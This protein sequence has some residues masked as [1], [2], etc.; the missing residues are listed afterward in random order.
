M[1]TN[2][3]LGRSALLQE[4]YQQEMEIIDAALRD[5]SQDEQEERLSLVAQSWSLSCACF[6]TESDY[7]EV[8]VSASVAYAR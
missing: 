7:S 3:D 4:Q 6:R 2:Y 5:E 8:P 1:S